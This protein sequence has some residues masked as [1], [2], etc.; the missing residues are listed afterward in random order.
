VAVGDD[1]AARRLASPS[2]Q[3]LGMHEQLVATTVG[4]D[5]TETAAMVPARNT[6]LITHPAPLFPSLPMGDSGLE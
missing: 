4:H 1:L 6:T 5:V 2:T 3:R